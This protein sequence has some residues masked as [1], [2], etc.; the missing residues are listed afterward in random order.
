MDAT[1]AGLVQ[2]ALR[3]EFADLPLETVHECKRRLV[4]TFAC[5]V[6]AYDEDFSR[7]ARAVARRYSGMPAAGVWG[8]G[9]RTTPEAAAF[10]NGVMLRFLDLS[11]TYVVKS[12]G[13]PSDVI[14]PI[15]AVGEA[16]HAD[17]AS[18]INAISLAY[19]VYCN[20]IEAI[21]INSKGWDQPVYVVLAAVLGVGRL[22]R[23]TEEQLGNAV[24]L[25]LA[26][27][28]ALEQTRRGELSSWKGCAAANASRNAVFAALLAR[29][30]FAG[31]TAVFEGKSGLWD[32]VGRFDWDLP[33]GRGSSHRIA[34]THIKC[35]PIC[36]H[37]QSA[38]WAA[39]EIRSRTP[40]RE[41]QEV[42]IEAYRQAVEF[43]G[44]DPFRWAPTTRE[45]AD[46]SLPYVVAIA[47][48]DGE[49]TALSFSSE[50]LADPAVIDL[51]R[52][53]RVTERADLSAQYPEC[54]PCRLA[55]RLRSGDEI[56]TEVRYP[57]GHSKNPVDD[58]ELEAK[59]RSMFREY[60]NEKQCTMALQA[61]WNIDRAADVGEVLKVFVTGADRDDA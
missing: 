4:D 32:I 46:H 29:D 37:G 13:H 44:N 47:L 41:I 2:F 60:G 25:A 14:A 19:D 57:R 50:R 38:A 12:N 28:M 9:W 24:A 49:I 35:L 42:H 59:F 21:D 51:M 52:R 33:V 30:G 54:T 56:R 43:M 55:I 31:P 8:C 27:N 48:L 1:T 10:A 6:G 18:V 22:L 16:V 61:V 39:L 45:T 11:D 3:S 17:G 23:L 26:P 5:A 7:M 40:V 36:Y 58:L 53:I 20:F 34:R 15:M